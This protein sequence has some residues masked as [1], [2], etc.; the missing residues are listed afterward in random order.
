MTHIEAG[1][2]SVEELRIAIKRHMFEADLHM[3]TA[4]ALLEIA[5][6]RD[7]NI[8]PDTEKGGLLQ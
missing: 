3:R 5:C 2:M 8:E 6:S 1:W 4:E 7:L